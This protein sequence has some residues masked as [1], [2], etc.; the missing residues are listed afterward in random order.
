M[1]K[2]KMTVH[3][4]KQFYINLLYKK[5]IKGNIFS[6]QSFTFWN[7][8]LSS[9]TVLNINFD[10]KYFNKFICLSWKY[11]SHCLTNTHFKSNLTWRHS[12]Y[13]SWI[14]MFGSLLFFLYVSQRP[15][16]CLYFIWFSQH[17]CMIV[18][19]WKK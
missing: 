17:L 2:R 6:M 12:H 15:Y 4:F 8:P 1:S 18:R 9:Y 11:I 16:E 14:N 19:M 7:V 13:Y 5:K 3:I 10:I